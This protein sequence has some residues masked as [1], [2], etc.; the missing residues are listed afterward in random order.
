MPP[1]VP[2]V[3]PCEPVGDCACGPIGAVMQTGS[4]QVNDEATISVSGAPGFTTEV[5][6]FVGGDW[7]V[8]EKLIDLVEVD[9]T[10]DT[11][12]DP[13]VTSSFNRGFD[14]G[15][16]IPSATVNTPTATGVLT[17]KVAI[18]CPTGVEVRTGLMTV[19]VIA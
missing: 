1:R 9:W 14:L 17:F 4:T 15:V 18:T 8:G 10:P 16:F 12:G 11:T 3:A 19:T 2:V 5:D 7:P 6:V 13:P